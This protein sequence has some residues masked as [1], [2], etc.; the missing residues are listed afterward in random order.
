MISETEAYFEAKDKSFYKKKHRIVGE[1]LESMYHPSEKT[2]LM[3]KVEFCRKLLFYYLGLGLI[4]GWFVVWVSG[5]ST[6]VGYL[7]PNPFLYK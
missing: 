1:A 2:M 7:M 4:D 5:I 6:F 3:N